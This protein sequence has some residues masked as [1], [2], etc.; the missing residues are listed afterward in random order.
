MKKNQG[1]SVVGILFTIG[2]VVC[3]GILVMRVSVVY[4]HHYAI[5]SSLQALNNIPSNRFSHNPAM[6]Q[7]VLKKSLLRRLEI[8]SIENIK[9]DNIKISRKN[10]NQ[11]LVN[12][13]YQ[14]QAP[15]FYNISLLF[16]FDA[17]QEVTIGTP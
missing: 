12:I 9:S 15:L 17:S 8:N 1:M 13:H 3:L 10:P 6:N 11:Y 4:I 2:V 5:T 16:K 7:I 14:T